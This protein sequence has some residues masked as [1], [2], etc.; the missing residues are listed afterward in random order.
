M[1]SGWTPSGRHPGYLC[2]PGVTDLR[3][4]QRAQDC[5][6]AGSLRRVQT[7]LCAEAGWKSAG[8]PCGLGSGLRSQA[9]PPPWE[10]LAGHPRLIP[11]PLLPIRK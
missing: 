7:H 11:A 3:R 8:Q 2:L 1:L 4:C 5:R 6:P 10:M 9:A